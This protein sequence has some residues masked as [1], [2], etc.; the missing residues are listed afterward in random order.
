[1]ALITNL[2]A[3]RLRPVFKWW[4]V[5]ALVVV[6]HCAAA[7]QTQAPALLV[8]PNTN[9]AVALESITNRREPFSPTSSVQFGSDSRTRIAVFA[10]NAQLNTGE[11]ISAFAADVQD[12][13]GRFYPLVSRKRS[14]VAG[15]IRDHDARAASQRWAVERRRCFTAD[16]FARFAEQS[17]AGWYRFYRWRTAG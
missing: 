8:Q 6:A 16:Q 10:L 11:G 14:L 9:R 3:S 12:G 15:S 4:Q 13:S 1:M 17:R 5:C 7:A 2:L